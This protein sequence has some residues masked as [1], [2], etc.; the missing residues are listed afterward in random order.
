[1]MGVDRG[2]AGGRPDPHSLLRARLADLID[3][4]P[5]SLQLDVESTA[6]RFSF[7]YLQVLNT[8]VAQELLAY[9]R[10]LTKMRDDLKLALN[11]SG[12]LFLGSDA[13]TAIID[14]VRRGVVPRSWVKISFETRRSLGPWMADLELR[15]AFFRDW[16]DSGEPARV[17]LAAFMQPQAFLVGM[18][19]RYAR[20]SG[21]P[22]YDV[23]F[24][25]SVCEPG[26]SGGTTT[27]GGGGGGGSVGGGG[28]DTDDDD[29]DDNGSSGIPRVDS[30]LLEGLHLEGAQWS[31]TYK[32]LVEPSQAQYC[33]A[34]PLLRLQLEGINTRIFGRR[35]TATGAQEEN[36]A[37]APP[38]NRAAGPSGPGF[39]SAGGGADGSGGHGA[40][41][42]GGDDGFMYKC[43]VFRTRDRGTNVR[44]QHG[45]NT[46]S[47]LDIE[48]PSR[49]RQPDHWVLRAVVLLLEGN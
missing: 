46:A 9:N 3:H 35:I 29:D 19:L 39:S 43:P 32:S 17:W 37:R 31:M 25:A 8:V 14:A 7:K 30:C 21:I 12:G 4:I 23:R 41:G 1:M 38:S 6:S 5:H 11:S 49:T 36:N 2:A 44:L 20:A 48:L 18:Q 26:S 33:S 34:I 15:V 24:I 16:V 10:L 45:Q 42:G 47:L 40:G 28:N 22:H 27:G 13:V